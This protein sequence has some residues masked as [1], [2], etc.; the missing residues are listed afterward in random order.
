MSKSFPPPRC[1]RTSVSATSSV[2]HPKAGVA[3]FNCEGAVSPSSRHASVALPPCLLI[4]GRS[5]TCYGG[6]GLIS[7][8]CAM[9]DRIVAHAKEQSK[10]RAALTLGVV[11]LCLELTPGITTTVACLSGCCL[12]GRDSGGSMLNQ[13]NTQSRPLALQSFVHFHFH[14]LDTLTVLPLSLL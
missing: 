12:C 9:V 14:F 13:I 1:T 6:P 7:Q 11:W 4:K 2:G 10:H 8:G 3:A 5:V